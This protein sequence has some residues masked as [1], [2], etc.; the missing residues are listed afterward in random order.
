MQMDNSGVLLI[1]IHQFPQFFPADLFFLTVSRKGKTAFF[2]ES[3]G[4]V[5]VLQNPKENT[6]KPQLFQFALTGSKKIASIAI[7]DLFGEVV[8]G[9]DLTVIAVLFPP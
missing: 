6:P 5:I 9:Y 3:S 2:I 4:A 1:H 8:D 7:A